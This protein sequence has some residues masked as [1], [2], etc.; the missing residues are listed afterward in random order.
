MS[1]RAL[2]DQDFY[3]WANEQAGLLRAGRLS[4]A[5]IEHIADEIEST[6]KS[7]K[8]ELVSRLTVL[9]THLLKWQ[10]QPVLRGTSW[11]LALEEQRDR[12]EDH[13]GDNPSLKSTLDETIG[14]AYHYAVLRAARE[15]G[16]E[17]S[18][19]PVAGPWPFPQIMDANFY[20]E[21]AH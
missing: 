9:L 1:N 14:T 4:E 8:R 11:R 13:L 20:P 5:D 18:V 7:E 10:Y 17:R 19:F 6:G 3:A 12:L 16:L 21:V 2:Y 15:I